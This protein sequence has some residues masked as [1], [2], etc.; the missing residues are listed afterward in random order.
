MKVIQLTTILTS[1]AVPS[2]FYGDPLPAIRGA[3]AFKVI[4]PFFKGF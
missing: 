2:K 4:I 1:S 3:L